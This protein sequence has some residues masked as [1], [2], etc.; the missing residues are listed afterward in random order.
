MTKNN[1][2]ALAAAL[3]AQKPDGTKSMEQAAYQQWT[4]DVIAVMHVCTNMNPRFSK[5]KFLAA[6]GIPNILDK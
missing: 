2:A 5:G 3:K 1:F 4:H 6:C